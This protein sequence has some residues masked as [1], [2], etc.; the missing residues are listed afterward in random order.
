M[1]FFF[2]GKTQNIPP[3]STFKLTQEGR[4]KVQQFGGDDK[5]RVL[6]ALETRGTSDIDEISAA[7]GLSRG[8]VEQLVPMLVR[9]RFIQL[10]GAS[11]EEA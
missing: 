7:S 11:T 5:S 8:K 10:V 3:G 1:S 6:V 2:K 4:E 9:G